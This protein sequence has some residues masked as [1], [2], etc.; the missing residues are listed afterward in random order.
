MD[1]KQQNF[2]P[3]GQ[4]IPIAGTTLCEKS[5]EVD[6][7]AVHKFQIRLYVEDKVIDQSSWKTHTYTKLA[8]IETRLSDQYNSPSNIQRYIIYQ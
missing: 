1:G 3:L 7:E 6:C 2:Q 8:D 4:K 5:K